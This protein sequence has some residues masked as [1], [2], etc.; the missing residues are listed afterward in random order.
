[1]THDR[2]AQKGRDS[3]LVDFNEKARLLRRNTRDTERPEEMVEEKN[4][5]TD[6]VR[7]SMLRRLEA[8][9][10][11]LD[12]V[13]DDVSEAARASYAWRSID[14]E[15]A[16][17]SYDSLLDADLLAGVRAGG[18]AGR[19]LT[20]EALR[21]VLEVEVTD[22]RSRSLTCQVV[23]PQSASLELRHRA[24]CIQLGRDDYGTFHLAALPEGPISLRCIPDHEELGP[25]ATSWV[26]L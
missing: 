19:Q 21:L 26:T 6:L 11:E 23:P 20:F 15:L 2:W 3:S 7:L 22:G 13:P 25:V 14:D 4:T 1:M 17:L 5:Q 8:L 24:G 10:Q 18:A 16:R 9:A 12:P